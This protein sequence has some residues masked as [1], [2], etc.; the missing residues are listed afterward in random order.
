MIELINIS[1]HLIL[2][3]LLF[4][5][6]LEEV[7]GKTIQLGFRLSASAIL[8]LITYFIFCIFGINSN[9]VEIFTI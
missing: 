2:I 1:I 4:H 7:T 8:I 3:I 9:Y 6:P 5:L